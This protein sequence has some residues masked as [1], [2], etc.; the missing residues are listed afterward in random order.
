[1]R[2]ILMYCGVNGEECV[3]WRDVIYSDFLSPLKDLIFEVSFLGSCRPIWCEIDSQGFFGL[4]GR[5]EM[6]RFAYLGGIFYCEGT[7]NIG[8]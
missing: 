3:C 1:M 6:K 8:R 4:G 5:D 2:D 7:L